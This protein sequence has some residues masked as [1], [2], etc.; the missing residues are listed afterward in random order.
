MDITK[1]GLVIVVGL[2][3]GYTAWDR[4]KPRIV[5]GKKIY[6][7]TGK[8][9]MC[10]YWKYGFTKKD[11]TFAHRTWPCGTRAYVVHLKTGRR[12]LG[13]VADR[14]PYGARGLKQKGSI[15]CKKSGEKGW[16]VKLPRRRS[17]PEMPG[18]WRGVADLSVSLRRALK[19]NG[20][21]R[22]ALITTKTEIARARKE[23]NGRRRGNVRKGHNKRA[24]R[25]THRR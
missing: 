15:Y 6:L 3:S 4:G 21:T 20:Y 9:P 8:G 7:S 19:H 5:A 16:C 1:L 13:V 24:D 23:F 25:A 17:G 12:V 2:A 11:Y 10:N 22:V 14:G 18:V